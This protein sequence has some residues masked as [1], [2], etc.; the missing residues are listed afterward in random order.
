MPVTFLLNTRAGPD[1]SGSSYVLQDMPGW[2]VAEN[3]FLILLPGWPSHA[4]HG[5]HIGLAT[6][7]HVVRRKQSGKTL[8]FKVSSREALCCPGIPVPY[9]A[10]DLGCEFTL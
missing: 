8:S 5:A 2:T 4:A 3:Y 10:Q 6:C 7:L 1:I 9:L